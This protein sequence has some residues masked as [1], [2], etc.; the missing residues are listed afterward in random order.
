LA[1]ERADPRILPRGLAYQVVRDRG[2]SFQ[3]LSLRLGP[4][5]EY[6]GSSWG[7]F[8]LLAFV[9]FMKTRTH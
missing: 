1:H 7:G 6:P 4:W 9:V 2:G 5:A 3:A 8:L